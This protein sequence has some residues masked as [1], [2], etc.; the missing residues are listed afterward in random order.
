[1]H[2]ESAEPVEWVH[3][4][5]PWPEPGPGRAPGHAVPSEVSVSAPPRAPRGPRP[6]VLRVRTPRP[7]QSRPPVY[8]P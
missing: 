2:R 3:F 6:T 8:L 7:T 1:M 4:P 5:A